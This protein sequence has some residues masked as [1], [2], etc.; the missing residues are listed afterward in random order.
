MIED[1]AAVA[2]LFIVGICMFLNH[3]YNIPV[4]DGI[5]S[6][7]VGLILIGVSAILARESRSL[8]MGEGIS[9]ESRVKITALVERDS[10]VLKVM[11]MLS[12]YQSP[13]EIILMLIVAL[14]EDLDTQQINEAIDRIRDCIKQE[15][16]LVRFVLVQPESFS[17]EITETG[18]IL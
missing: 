17:A 5:A 11:H 2:G 12:T 6:L 7:L 4:L 16:S 3:R 8:L 18:S 13:D 9:S 15:F 14:K 10:T 1:S